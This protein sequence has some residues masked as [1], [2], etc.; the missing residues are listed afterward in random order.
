MQELSDI[1]KSGI[2]VNNRFN[3]FKKLTLSENDKCSC[4]KQLAINHNGNY[5]PMKLLFTCYLSMSFEDATMNIERF[6]EIL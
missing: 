1:D 6:V 3:M 5:H 4:D 2:D